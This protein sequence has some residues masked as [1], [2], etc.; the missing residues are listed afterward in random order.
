MTLVALIARP[1]APLQALADAPEALALTSD[2]HGAIVALP[3]LLVE[4]D[5]DLSI[6][7]A[8]PSQVRIAVEWSGTAPDLEVATG[9]AAELHRLPP[10][11][12]RL[13]DRTLIAAGRLDEAE[14]TA[15]FW[16][17]AIADDGAEDLGQLLE[18]AAAVGPSTWPRTDAERA[19]DGD[20]AYALPPAGSSPAVEG[21]AYPVVIGRPGQG[22]PYRLAG[23]SWVGAAPA[24]PGLAVELTGSTLAPGDFTILISSPPIAA[25]SATRISADASGVPVVDSVA[26][27]TIH[28]A[29]GRACSVCSP[30]SS[31]YLPGEDAE[32]WIAIE[33]GDGIADPYGV[34]RLRRADHVIRWALDRS[35]LRQDRRQA[36]RLGALAGYQIDV[37]IYSQVRPIDWLQSQILSLLPARL[38]RGPAGAYVWPVLEAP[39]PSLAVRRLEVGVDAARLGSW[40]AAPLAPVGQALIRYG[41]DARRGATPRQILICGRPADVPAGLDLA[42][43]L[44]AARGEQASPRRRITIDA[45]I[46]SDPAT[47]TRIGRWA[48]RQAC[49]PSWSVDLALDDPGE[50]MPGDVVRVIDSACGVEGVAQVERLRYV[51]GA[52]VATVRRYAQLGAAAPGV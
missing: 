40:I 38:A 41:W 45:P 52:A 27:R 36:P 44:W 3:G 6:G 13:C 17:A 19:A 39:D 46:T 48:I 31:L 28:D 49:R 22:I 47:A 21:A 30:S 7:E 43:D 10:G 23:V 50:L 8:A 33:S 42:A 25:T 9:A 15:A 32:H 35:T 37:A 11:Q 20:P 1:G 18:P 26:V 51:G 34:G 4:G 16:S 5:L 12:T 29:L 2:D 24:V 14:I